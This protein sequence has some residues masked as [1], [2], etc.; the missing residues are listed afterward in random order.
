MKYTLARDG[1]TLGQFTEAQLRDGLANGFCQQTDLV[2]G[3]GM[4]DW[5]MLGELF[6]Q[7][8]P[9]GPPPLHGPQ[10]PGAA[11]KSSGIGIVVI[12]VGVVI[13]AAIFLIAILAAVALPAF[14]RT[15]ERAHQVR[16]ISNA[17]QIA[18]GLRVHAADNNG[19]YPD[20]LLPD[21][22]SS[23]EVFGIL[24]KQGYLEDEKV[25]GCPS[26]PYQPD[27]NIGTDPDF[28]N[29]LEAGENHW[30]MTR[31]L[32]DSSPANIPLIYENPVGTNWPAQW[33]SSHKGAAKPG[34]A[35]RDGKIVIVQSDGGGSIVP[36]TASKGD[37][38]GC[39]PRENGSPVFPMDNPELG[40]LNV[41]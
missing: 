1:Q 27:G 38:V 33:N 39:R 19:T 4:T 37:A 23:N 13:F 29:A 14:S 9:A 20:A 26:S 10:M 25:F 31:G 18:L 12:V 7:L 15:T 34:R 40:I 32:S 17:R 6:P 5:K 22:G 35:W 2:W 24:F 36:L 30:A 28:L 16:A 21:A 41:K 8:S 3:D 11:K